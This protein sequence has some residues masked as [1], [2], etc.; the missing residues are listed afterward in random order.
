MRSLI[1]L[2]LAILAP[3]CH[4]LLSK[5]PI[6]PPSRDK[7]F[8]TLRKSLTQSI[9]SDKQH[10][11]ITEYLSV[12]QIRQIESI[13]SES[14][15]DRKVILITSYLLIFT[16]NIIPHRF[17]MTCPDQPSLISSSVC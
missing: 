17:L 3:S 1:I 13:I 14:D 11:G 12:N 5:N 7:V 15:L 9:P 2:I 8:S 4:P 6:R 10:H 16:F